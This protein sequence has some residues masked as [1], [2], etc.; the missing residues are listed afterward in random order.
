MTKKAWVIT[1]LSALAIF[2]GGVSV[3]KW[4][5]SPSEGRTI[6]PDSQESRRLPT[7]A[8]PS[9]LGSDP[10]LT[11]C[12][13]LETQISLSLPKME[14]SAKGC[15]LR[16]ALNKPRGQVMISL[17]RSALDTA[18]AGR[19]P[20]S[21]LTGVQLRTRET[22]T[23][24]PVLEL[25]PE[26]SLPNSTLGSEFQIFTTPTEITGFFATAD[27]A[28]H[29]VVTISIH[30]VARLNPEVV[31]HFWQLVRDVTLTKVE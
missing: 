4:S 27:P 28:S 17:E 29:D 16:T 18:N 26:L 30:S 19:A 2:G 14:N 25:P 1:G 9:T 24:T 5:S 11:N 3:W 20:L 10:L 6:P 12:F 31:A 8:S 13:K 21:N 22:T 7:S 15:V 23:Y